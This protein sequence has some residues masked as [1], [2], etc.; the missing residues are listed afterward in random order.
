MAFAFPR[1]EMLTL[2]VRPDAKLSGHSDGFTGMDDAV[3]TLTASLATATSLASP[4]RILA[5]S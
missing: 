3:A 2:P 5:R 1:V 4:S